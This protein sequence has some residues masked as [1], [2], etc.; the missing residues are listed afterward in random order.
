MSDYK[1]LRVWK[2]A[3]KLALEIYQITK[4][5]P[6]EEKY[7]LVSQIRRAVSS[8]PTNI[9][10]G[11]GQ[12]DNSNLVRFLGIA[13]GSAF[14]LEYLILLSKDLDYLKKEEYSEVNEK[15]EQL[16]GMVTNLIKPLNF[17]KLNHN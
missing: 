16:I 17:K 9:V 15:I 13:R 10:E 4:V 8:I 12:L 3:H 7:G 6:E 5:F 2:Y 14:E 1:K 11:C